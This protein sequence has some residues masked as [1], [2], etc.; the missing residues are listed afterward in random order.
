MAGRSAQP[1]NY[2]DV[3]PAEIVHDQ[4]HE[5]ALPGRT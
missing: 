2:Q 5:V 4:I 3:D 1:D